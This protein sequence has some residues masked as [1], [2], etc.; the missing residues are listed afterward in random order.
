[1]LTRQALGQLGQMRPT[2]A[3]RM[4]FR[5][6]MARI[7][8]VAEHNQIQNP[9][10]ILVGQTIDFSALLDSRAAKGIAPAG[11]SQALGQPRLADTLA[12]NEAAAVVLGERT[13]T[14]YRVFER[15]LDRAVAK[16]YIPKGEVADVRRRILDMSREHRFNP[17]DFARVA[18][19]ESDGLNPRATNG[20]CHGVIQFC[21]GPDRGAASAGYGKQ[22]EKILDL[23]VLEQL[24]L[25]ERYFEDTGLQQYKPASLDN[26]YL[27]VLYPAG[28]SERQMHRNLGVPGPQ[29]AALHVGGNQNA[30][31]TRA[32]LRKGLLENANQRLTQFALAQAQRE[33]AARTEISSLRRP[34][35]RDLLAVR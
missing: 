13:G 32:S 20:N 5:D 4:P 10:R 30:P 28:R 11:H 25:V 14:Q 35:T 33:P 16:G 3:Q 12:S 29:A 8:T 7:H 15:T 19:M 1:G 34:A 21:D 2:D 23:S 24:D 26:L 9:D 27:T 6:L 31:I 18:L 17:D 22:P